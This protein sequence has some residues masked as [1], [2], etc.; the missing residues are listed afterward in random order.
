MHLMDGLVD[1]GVSSPIKAVFL[2]HDEDSGLKAQTDSAG[3][4]DTDNALFRAQKAAAC[5]CLKVTQNG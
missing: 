4:G 5:L 3:D 2:Q 1:Q